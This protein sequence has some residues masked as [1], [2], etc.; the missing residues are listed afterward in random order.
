MPR[1]VAL[2]NLKEGVAK[3]H[4]EHWAL[5]TDLP[6]VRGLS[7]VNGFSTHRAV[8]ILGS[9]TA[10][11]YQYIEVIDVND[12]TVFGEELSTETMQRVAAEFQAF[13]DNPCFILTE[14]L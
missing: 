2:F 7:S 8:G 5:N 1:I 12:M 3:A 9:D 6:T 13:A 11:P 4:Y 14:E 10:P